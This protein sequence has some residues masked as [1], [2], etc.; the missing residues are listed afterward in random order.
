VSPE[1][2]GP[3][4]CCRWNNDTCGRLWP[5]EKASRSKGTRSVTAVDPRLAAQCSAVE[6]RALPDANAAWREENSLPWHSACGGRS[7]GHLGAAKSL[8]ATVYRSSALTPC[9]CPVVCGFILR[10]KFPRPHGG[11]DLQDTQRYA[12]TRSVDSRSRS[13]STTTDPRARDLFPRGFNGFLLNV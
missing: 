13:Q 3:A 1:K 10:S 12:H 6:Q 8:T 9:P 5:Q 2:K 11:P 4:G 7:S